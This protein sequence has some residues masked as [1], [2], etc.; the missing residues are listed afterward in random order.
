MKLH[1]HISSAQGNPGIVTCAGADKNYGHRFS[2]GDLVMFSGVEGMVELNSSKPCPVRV[3]GEC[4]PQGLRGSLVVTVT[5]ILPCS[6]DGFRLEIGDTSTF[7][8]YCGGGRVS[9]V[10]PRQEHSYV[11]AP[12]PPQCHPQQQPRAPTMSPLSP[13]CVSRSPSA[14]RWRCPGSRPGAPRSC[15]A[16][17][18]CTLPSRPCTPSAKSGAACLSP[19][20]L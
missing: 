7:S 18:V 16:A 15:C 4:P 14:R 8:P 2:D 17:A 9:E 10:R 3:L 6:P 12:V 5:P 20:H 1:A 19:G 11:R 13:C